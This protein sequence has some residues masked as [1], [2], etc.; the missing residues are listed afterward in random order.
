MGR[1]D[2]DRIGAG[3]ARSRR[4][5]ERWM[6]A[7]LG[8]LG[9]ATGVVN[10]GAGTGSY[11]PDDRWVVA[12]EPSVVMISQ[13]PHD[14][15]PV[16]RGVAEA[17]PFRAG[18]F[19]A[20]LAVLTVH[21][22]PDPVAGLHE[23]SRVAATQVVLTFTAEGHA[24]F[25]LVEDYLP[26]LAEEFHRTTPTLELLESVLG[27]VD[28]I[29]VLVPADFADGV[30]AAH[31]ARPHAYLHPLV[32]GSASSLA[33]CDPRTLRT[34]MGRLRRDLADGTWHARHGDLLEH[35]EYDAGYRL[36]VAGAGRTGIGPE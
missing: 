18:A 22:W 31:W 27:P 30:L 12:V 7:V 11:E 36:V 35:A 1:T 24:G 29:P 10:V 13:R 6:G 33:T 2:Y 32:Q 17:L 26:H 19:D 34:A 20:A 14:A 5:D 23:L 21:H 25:W 9:A 16:V 3:Y 15:A 4:S 28:V 8:A